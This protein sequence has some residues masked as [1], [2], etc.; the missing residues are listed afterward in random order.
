MDQ[1]SICNG[2]FDLDTEGGVE[3]YIG[4][5]PVQFCPT[6]YAGIFD[7]VQQNCWRCIEESE[8][9]NG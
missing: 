5:L 9:E 1:C 2:D 4:I 7:L 3:G 6:C 8:E